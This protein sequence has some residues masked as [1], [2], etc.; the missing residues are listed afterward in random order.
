MSSDVTT[1]HNRVNDRASIDCW[2]F[3]LAMGGEERM[4]GKPDEMDEC[5]R[6]FREWFS[7]EHPELHDSRE[8]NGIVIKMIAGAAFRTAWEARAEFEEVKNG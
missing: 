5:S 2:P 6:K 1:L 8:M 7:T 4:M 3:S